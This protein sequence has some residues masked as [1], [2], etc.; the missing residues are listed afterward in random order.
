[1]NLQDYRLSDTSEQYVPDPA[2]SRHTVHRVSYLAGRSS[3]MTGI[4]RAVFL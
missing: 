2:T 4:S 1:M 3:T